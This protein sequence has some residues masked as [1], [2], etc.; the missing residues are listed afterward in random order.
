MAHTYYVGLD[1]HKET[2]SIAHALEGIR[3][4]ATYHGQCSGSI[5]AVGKALQKLAE[6]LNVELRDLKACYEAAPPAL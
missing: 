3:D 5:A 4:D 1:V 2:I 6:K